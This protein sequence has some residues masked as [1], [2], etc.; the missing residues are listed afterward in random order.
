M[1]LFYTGVDKERY[2]AGKRFMPMDKYL[3]NYNDSTPFNFSNNASAI[4]SPGITATNS[5][6]NFANNKNNYNPTGGNV[7]GYGNAV[8]PVALGSY[9]DPSYFGGLDGNIQQ[10]GIP[11]NF[12]YD[13]DPNYEGDDFMTAY[14]MTTGK[15]KELPGF[16]NFALSFLPGGSFI[17]NKIEKGLNDPRVGQPNYRIGGM[18]NI[19]KG[20]YNMLAGQGMLFDG[21][22][23][24][25]TLT[26]KNFTGKGYLEGQIDIYN[27]EFTKPD[28][29]MMTE[30][31]ITDLIAK[32]KADPRKQFKYKQMLEASTMYKTNKAQEKFAAEQKAKQEEA[33]AQRQRDIKIAQSTP[34][35]GSDGT[36]GG[37]FRGGAE[38]RGANPYGGSGK[39]D[40]LGADTFK[41][42][43]LAS[44]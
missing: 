44:L 23:G 1:S 15:N 27:K 25:K 30:E 42:G 26:G 22:G 4:S 43:G 11:R 6:M 28:G 2:D 5:F 37:D 41:Y 13:M 10:S 7:F 21:P 12:M 18:D 32:T 39:M 8:S 38:F 35:G 19:Q 40:D 17:R 34:L 31:E 33:A 29:T 16:A 36:S 24:V 9:G 20:Q 14:Q 3:L